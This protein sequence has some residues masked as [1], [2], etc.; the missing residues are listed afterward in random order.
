[1]NSIEFKGVSSTT[2]D[3]LLICELPPISKP[4]MRVLETM[5]DGRHGSIFEDL[6]Y[7][8]YDKSV[9]I[10][11]HGAFDI[12]KVIKF[13]S[14]EGDIVFGNE[15]NKVYHGKV[16][17][18][19]DYNRLLRFRKATVTFRVQPFKH[20]Y[21]EAYTETK[22]V[23]ASGTNLVL[24]DCGA[25]PIQI[26]TQAEKI[27]VHGKNIV[28]PSA[29]SLHTSTKIDV[30]E[31]GYK[32]I[33][34][35]GTKGTYVTTRYI[36]PLQMK[37]KQYTLKCDDI[38]N[39]QNASGGVQIV[40]ETPSGPK[41]IGCF[42]PK[43]SVDFVIPEE[44]TSINLGIYTNNTNTAL[45]TDNVVVVKGLRIVPIE[46][47]L[48]DW[49]KFQ[50]LQTISVADGVANVTGIEPVTVISNA[51]NVEMSVEYFK[52]Y[53]VFNEGLEVSKPMMVLKGSGKVKVRVNGN[54]TFEYTFPGGENEVVIDSEAEDAHLNGILKN[55]NML[56][57]FP[58]LVPKTNKIEWYGDVESIA[59]LPRSRWL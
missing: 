31:D 19:I 13:F 40:V 42:P 2:I 8:A 9:S 44:A 35:G 1:M 24:N 49:C 28:N 38:T 59:I 33:V 26:T 46:C 27:L 53:E 52:P 14:G 50:Y 4:P 36:L 47:K 32:I 51:D 58:E 22:T 6:G 29:F 34:T 10:G 54:A 41:Y 39:E 11:L 48:D 37:G 7:S 25:T 15:P 43:K 56:G 30:L 20:K 5:V 21:R 17:G 45:A 23:T 12:D 57:E 3:G 55:R 16:I 18:R